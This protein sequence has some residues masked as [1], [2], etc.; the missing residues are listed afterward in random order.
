MFTKGKF[1]MPTAEDFGKFWQAVVGQAADVSGAVAESWDK[2]FKQ[3]DELDKKIDSA[4]K[5]NITYT[6]VEF[7]QTQ[8]LMS[9]AQSIIAQGADGIAVFRVK[10]EDGAAI[11]NLANVKGRELL[12]PETNKYAIIKAAALSS[13]VKELFADGELQILN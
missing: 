11:I 5:A 8:Q 12:P 13:D 1:N 3:L 2:A 4:N 7:L 9:I 10:G 6:E